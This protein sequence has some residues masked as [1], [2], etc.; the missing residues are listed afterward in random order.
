MAA[1][2]RRPATSTA[3][4]SACAVRVSC[5]FAYL[6]PHP[7][8]EI[9]GVADDVQHSTMLNTGLNLGK[10][11]SLPH[12][13]RVQGSNPHVLLLWA[14]QAASRRASRTRCATRCRAS[15]GPSSD[16]ST[17][18]QAMPCSCPRSCGV[19][20][21]ALILD[22]RTQPQSLCVFDL[23][24]CLL[25]TRTAGDAV[26]SDVRHAVDLAGAHRAHQGGNLFLIRFGRW[27]LGLVSS[28]GLLAA[29]CCCRE[30]D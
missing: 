14:L 7:R 29:C 6:W 25:F 23:R 28:L 8:L 21:L 30:L 10:G 5:R 12:S 2:P 27:L 9:A 11:E 1:S 16:A 26:R 19:S 22:S 4:T 15:R 3:S 13:N 18:R 24:L 20:D 17:T